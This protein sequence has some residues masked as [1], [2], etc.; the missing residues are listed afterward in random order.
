MGIRRQQRVVDILVEIMIQPTSQFSPDQICSLFTFIARQIGRTSSSRS[1][2]LDR[3]VFHQLVDLVCAQSAAAVAETDRPGPVQSRFEERQQALLSL[4]QAK[5]DQ[6]DE[7]DEEKLLT[8]ALSAQF[9]RVCEYIYEQ[10]KDW[11]QVVDCYVKDPG[12]HG[13]ILPL[14]RRL[15]DAQTD[16]KVQ[17]GMVDEAIVKH[18]RLLAGQNAADLVLFLV[19]DK[20]HLVS[21]A[22][23]ALG[24]NSDARWEQY[25][26]LEAVIE[27]A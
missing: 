26:F 7:Q 13:D 8:Q 11:K 20:P 18:I 4:L 16:D 24:R 15:A 9:Y 3:V 1:I 14:L 27:L 19:V 10:R 17:A 12:R 6:V 5:G 2:H 22:V 21:P 23:D 25:R